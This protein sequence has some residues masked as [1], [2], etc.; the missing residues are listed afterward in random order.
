MPKFILNTYFTCKKSQENISEEK[1]IY[2]L[3]MFASPGVGIKHR[4][5][6]VPGNIPVLSY[7]PSTMFRVFDGLLFFFLFDSREKKNK[8]FFPKIIE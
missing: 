6:L 8:T 3:P 7:T 2:V 4:I 1:S 5:L